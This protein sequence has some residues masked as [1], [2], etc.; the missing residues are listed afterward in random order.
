MPTGLKRYYGND[1][2]HFL[3]LQLLP[4]TAVA[5]LVPPPGGW[6][7]FLAVNTI[8]RLAAPRF[9]VF[10]A[11]AFL[12]SA[13]RDFPD[14]QLGLL[15]FVH[16]DRSRL[17][18]GVVAKAAPRPILR[19][20]HQSSLHRVAMHIPQLLHSLVFREDNEIVEWWLPDAPAPDRRLPQRYMFGIDR[21]PQATKQTSGESLLQ[22]FHHHGRIA[23]LRPAQ[24]LPPLITT[25]RDEVRVPC[26][27]ISMQPVGHGRGIAWAGAAWL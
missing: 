25:G 13:S 21:S 4:P 6:P 17:V 18:I 7:R 14:A 3:T 9:V 2:L 16:E 20:P 22:G 23:A 8:T 10:E 19:F 12:L 5:R 27:V 11:W 1:H 15:R 26:P 24:Q